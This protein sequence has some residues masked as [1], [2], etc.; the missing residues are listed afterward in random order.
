MAIEGQQ[1]KY[2]S[3]FVGKI[4]ET[5]RSPQSLCE[6]QWT[7]VFGHYEGILYMKG[8]NLYEV[9]RSF[10]QGRARASTRHERGSK[11]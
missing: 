8:R 1:T 3:G 2:V 10:K 7:E 9:T 6:G 5:K 11:Q 4:Y